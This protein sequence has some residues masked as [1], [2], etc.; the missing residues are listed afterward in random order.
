[1]ILIFMLFKLVKVNVFILGVLI[2]NGL[3]IVSI[4]NEYLKFLGVRIV[5]RVFIMSNLFKRV[6]NFIIFK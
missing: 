6:N 3:K 4:F 5:R 1:M 2:M